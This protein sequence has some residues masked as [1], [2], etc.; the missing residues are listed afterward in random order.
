MNLRKITTVM[1]YII[2]FL[3]LLE[4]FFVFLLGYF[5]DEERQGY[6]IQ[7]EYKDL[8]LSQILIDSNLHDVIIKY[9]LTKNKDYIDEFQSESVYNVN[10]FDFIDSHKDIK[11]SENDEVLINETISINEDMHILEDNILTAVKEGNENYNF[12]EYKY[13]DLSANLQENF[14]KIDDLFNAKIKRIIGERQRK[15]NY[16]RYIIAVNSIIIVLMYLVKSVIMAKIGRNG[17]NDASIF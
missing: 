11:I 2:I 8:Y 1:S 3:M 16:V 10:I 5:I 13:F 15:T 4:V 12:E 9:Y 14:N 6:D 7:N 17:K